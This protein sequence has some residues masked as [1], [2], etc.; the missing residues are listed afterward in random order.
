M[1]AETLAGVE[2]RLKAGAA[3]V[4]LG[5]FEPRA[6]LGH[7]AMGTVFKAWDTKLERWVAIKTVRAPHESDLGGLRREIGALWRLRHPGIVRIVDDGLVR[8]CPW[9]AMEL[10]RGSTLRRKP[11]STTV[12][13]RN[14]LVYS[15]ISASVRPE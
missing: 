15:A 13:S 14:H 1:D 12:C 9:F 8:G 4:R 7:G 5:R 3:V 10:L 2:A 6:I 11:S